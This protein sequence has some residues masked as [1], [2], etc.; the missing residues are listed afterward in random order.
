MVIGSSKAVA[1]KICTDVNPGTPTFL[2]EKRQKNQNFTINVLLYFG[3]IDNK[4]SISD[5]Y[6]PVSMEFPFYD[7]APTKQAFFNSQIAFENRAK[8]FYLTIHVTT[9]LCLHKLHE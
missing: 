4:I 1:A 7:L 5:G 2:T 9:F 6:Q 3:L 8:Q